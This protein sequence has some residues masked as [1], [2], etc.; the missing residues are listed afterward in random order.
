MISASEIVG[1]V[2]GAWRL[3]RRDP[4]GLIWFDASPE[5]AVRSFWG[6]ALVLPAYL[7]L[8]TLGGAF[9]HDV[10]VSLLVELIAFVIGVV[11]FPLA[12]FHIAQGVGRSHRY[13]RYVVAYNWSGVVQMAVL[14]PIALLAHL[15]PTSPLS[16]IKVGVSIVLLV[17]QGYV[18]H[19]ALE[20]NPASSALLVALDLLLGALIQTTAD[21]LAG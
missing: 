4:A 19:V 6:P 1:G 5:G 21:G 18:A 2:Y 12:V 10:A 9:E 14:L 7:V 15:F 3:A 11:A 20:V 17:Y 13:L 16:A 8:Q